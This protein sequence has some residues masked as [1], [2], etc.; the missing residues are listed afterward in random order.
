MTER[1][2]REKIDER[3]ICNEPQRRMYTFL[4]YQYDWVEHKYF[5]IGELP[6]QLKSVLDEYKSNAQMEDIFE[7]VSNVIK[8]E[9]VVLYKSFVE[10]TVDIYPEIFDGAK[11]ITIIRDDQDPRS[12]KL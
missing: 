4:P 5:H 8:D 12:C 2:V 3:W 6:I 11:S 7:Q 9:D 10:A 1:L